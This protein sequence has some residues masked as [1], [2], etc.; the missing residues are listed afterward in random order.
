MSTH[1]RRPRPGDSTPG[2]RPIWSG[3][4]L[5]LPEEAH[6]RLAVVRHRM[7]AAAWRIA[8]DCERLLDELDRPERH[9]WRDA[10]GE[11]L[12]ASRYLIARIARFA[13]SGESLD[14]G[15]FVELLHEQAREPQQRIIHATRTLLGLV[16]TGPNDELLVEDVRAVQEAAAS[17]LADVG[18]TPDGRPAPSAAAARHQRADAE[19]AGRPAPLLV[20]DDE[21]E[22]RRALT[23]LLTRLGYETL[24]A[25]DGRAALAIAERQP[26]DLILTDITM[27]ELDGFELLKRLKSDGHTRDI[28]VI[29]VSGVGDVESVVRCIEQGA[30][31]HV[32]KPFEVVLLQARV[33]ASL[34]RKRMRDLELA[35]LQRVAQLSAAAEAVEHGVYEPGSLDAL[36]SRDDALGRLARV[37]DRMV[38]GLRA[39][40]ERL[41][42]RLEHL[43]QEMRQARKSAG[44]RAPA[45][46]E[47]SPFAAGQVIADRYEIQGELGRGGMGMVYRA[48]DR[49]IGEEIAMKIVRPDHAAFPRLVDRL[50]SEIRLTRRIS[51]RNV[52]RAHDLGEWQGVYFLTME[53]V[54][55]ITVEAMLN[56]RG[57][58]SVD[59]TLAIGAQVAEALGVAHE[60]QIIH[61]DIKPANLLVDESGTLKVMDFGLA[62]VAEPGSGLTQAGFVVGTPGY[63]APEQHLGGAVDARSDLFSTGVV[64]YECLTGRPPFDASSPMAVVDRVLEGRVTPIRQ[65]LAHVP[66]ALAAVI[67]RLLRREPADRIQSA[68]ELAE[69][70]AQIGQTSH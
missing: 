34:E 14:P 9:L 49:Q 44:T 50:K 6:R 56:T 8:A 1:Q 30:E 35:D 46:S 63:M 12:L 39:R 61:R 40:E 20:V 52:V 36:G 65:L 45:V 41:E 3:E 67:E 55:G 48:R 21:P 54:K 60:L 59:S 11:A 70:L 25:G 18:P 2:G 19:L 10:V 32:T 28:P 47:A 43:R 33:R 26:L 5:A 38:S 31:D 29:V 37:F 42:Q 66:P 58:L 51:H 4:T 68:R 15:D 7:L 57:A 13:R 22:P 23:K 53:Y 27:P 24:E 17:L 64:L 16:P 62:R 69:Q